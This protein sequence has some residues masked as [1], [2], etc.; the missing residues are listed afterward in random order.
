[1]DRVL[2]HKPG[3]DSFIFVSFLCIDSALVEDVACKCV[4]IMGASWA[5]PLKPILVTILFCIHGTVSGINAL[6]PVSLI[7][8]DIEYNTAV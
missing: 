1:M 7:V 8:I 5:W 4:L 6:F 2:F 3:I